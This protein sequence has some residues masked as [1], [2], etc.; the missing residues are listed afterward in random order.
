MHDAQKGKSKKK[1]AKI[2]AKTANCKQR[3]HEANRMQHNRAP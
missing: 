1:S 2:P 3:S